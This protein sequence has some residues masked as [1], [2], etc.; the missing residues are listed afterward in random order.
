MGW[1]PGRAAP[2]PGR[3]GGQERDPDSVHG[4]P[5]RRQ[6]PEQQQGAVLLH[7][8]RHAGASGRPPVRSRHAPALTARTCT[9]TQGVAYVQDK[10]GIEALDPTRPPPSLHVRASRFSRI[11][12]PLRRAPGHLNS[13]TRPQAR[14]LELFSHPAAHGCAM[15]RKLLENPQA[16]GVRRKL[17]ESVLQTLFKRMW[18]PRDVRGMRP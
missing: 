4:G 2:R 12:T 1:R 9:R 3:R 6:V 14:V 15:V 11:Y 17:V 8:D 7:D 18:D 16:F 10:L 13:E 5:V